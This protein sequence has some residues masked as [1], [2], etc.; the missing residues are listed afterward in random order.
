MLQRQMEMRRQSRRRGNQID[1]LR[2]AVHRLERADPKQHVGVA[3][4]QHAHERRQSDAVV[5]IAAVR[6][7]MNTR[8]RD[9]L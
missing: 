9:L 6:A 3:T 8:D 5:E 1:D 7:E 2:R 4:R